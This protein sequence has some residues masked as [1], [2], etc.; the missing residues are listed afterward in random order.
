MPTDVGFPGTVRRRAVPR[1]QHFCAAA[2]EEHAKRLLEIQQR[3]LVHGISRAPLLVYS[4]CY[5]NNGYSSVTCSCGVCAAD[6]DGMRQ[7]TLGA[8]CVEG[9]DKTFHDYSRY[10]VSMLEVRVDICSSCAR[11]ATPISHALRP[12]CVHRRASRRGA[13]IRVLVRSQMRCSRILCDTHCSEG[14]L[15]GRWTHRQRT[16]TQRWRV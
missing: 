9:G 2:A 1:A 15:P 5:C 16:P 6:D 7:D 4:S 13:E 10:P 11:G 8:P 12:V 3:A 14:T